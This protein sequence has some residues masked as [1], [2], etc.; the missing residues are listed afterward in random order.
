MFKVSYT[1]IL[2]GA[3]WQDNGA[4]KDTMGRMGLGKK[5]ELG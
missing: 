1:V 2:N 5:Y 4:K 3:N